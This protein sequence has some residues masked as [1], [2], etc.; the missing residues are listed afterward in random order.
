[1]LS[2]YLSMNK[3]A[4]TTNSVQMLEDK[5]NSNANG[6]ATKISTKGGQ[7]LKYQ[8]KISSNDVTIPGQRQSQAQVH[9]PWFLLALPIVIYGLAQINCW[10]ERQRVARRRRSGV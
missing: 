9:F 8:A 2:L 5:K 1:M 6:N 10:I 7:G 3:N 4:G